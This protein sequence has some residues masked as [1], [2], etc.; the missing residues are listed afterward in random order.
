MATLGSTDVHVAQLDARFAAANRQGK[1]PVGQLADMKNR[2]T[3]G[4]Q[5]TFFSTAEA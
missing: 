4:R 3:L 2:R 5:L 1:G